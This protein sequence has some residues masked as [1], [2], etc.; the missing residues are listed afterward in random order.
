[1]GIEMQEYHRPESGHKRKGPQRNAWCS[2]GM[3]ITIILSSTLV[4]G[5]SIKIKTVEVSDTIAYAY[6]D[7]P[8]DLYIVTLA[9]QLQHFDK[10][11]RL[12][13]FYRKGPS[14]SLFDP[15]DGARLFAYY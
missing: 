13:M 10:D 5:Q 4:Y 2:F 11:G 14:L 1:M 9:G 7:R 8:G 6:V 3:M 12:S 15:R